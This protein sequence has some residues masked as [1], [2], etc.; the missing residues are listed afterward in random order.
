MLA[1]SRIDANDL[2]VGLAVHQT[3]IAVERIAANARGTRQHLA[4]CFVE[5]DADGK[6]EWKMPFP[7]E[8]IE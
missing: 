1:Q 3:R 5:Q 8:P 7:L 6:M 4:V 2:R